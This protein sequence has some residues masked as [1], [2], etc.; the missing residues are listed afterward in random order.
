MLRLQSVLAVVL[1]LSLNLPMFAQT[2]SFAVDDT[3]GF[4]AGITRDYR[5]RRVA[6][7]SFADS[8]R[9]EAL[10]RAGVIYLSLRDA[11][12]LALENNLDIETIRYDPKLARADLLRSSAGQLLRNVSS[13]ISSGPT[14]ASLSVLSGA[15]AVNAGTGATTT[16]SG[17]GGVLS[18]LSVQLAGSAIPNLDPTLF[19]QYQ[20]AHSTVIETSTVFTG[21]SALVTSQQNLVYGV[22]QGY[23]TGTQVTAYMSSVFG[24]KENATTALFNP[25]DSGSLNLNFTQNLLNGF[26]LAVNKRAYHK[27]INN[28]RVND[29]T[30]KQQVIA[31]VA[32]VANLYWDLVSF[33]EALKVDQETLRLDTQ[34]YEDNQRRAALGAIAPIDTIQAEADMKAEQQS[35]IA[36]QSQVLQQ[37]MILKSVLTRSGLDN[38]II[39]AARIVPTDHIDVPAQ[40][41]IIPLQELIEAAMRNRPELEQN[42][43]SLENTRLDMLGTKNNLLPTLSAFANFSN[44]G[45]AGALTT[46]PQ[47]Y[48]SSTGQLLGYKQLG[49]GD[50]NAFLLGGYGTVLSQIFS[51][52]FPNYS[53]GITLQVPIRN[54]AAQADMITTELNYRQQQIQEKQSR[55]GIKLNVINAATALQNARAAYDSAVI[56]ANLQDQTLA[57]T[58]RK[59][60]LGTAAILDVVIAQRD[61]TTRHL[62]E[63]DALDQYQR[64]RTNL[65]QMMGTILTTYDVDLEEARTG[66]VKRAPDAIPPGI[67]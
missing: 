40:E 67:R 47:P 60:D 30:F 18:G 4:F 57:G 62:S 43:L 46:V 1:C 29:L 66:Q 45:Q 22:Q 24:F 39:V 51:R 53:A 61:S 8:P 48:Y 31:T 26:G 65:Q 44:S 19:V 9:V 52:N 14:S 58:R 6:E 41:P 3:R 20:A 12:A 50:V 11:I 38:P 42:Q 21:T 35:V 37:E 27:A 64:A 7:V 15:S 32:N 13:N 33:N 34:L 55:N 25:I 2:Q 17:T 49:P 10:I 28:L 54:R 16:S 63:V 36:Q 23:W 59:Y 56:A 5:T